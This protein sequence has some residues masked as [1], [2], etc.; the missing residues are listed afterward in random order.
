M[1]AVLRTISACSGARI[2]GCAPPSASDGSFYFLQRLELVL[3][4]VGCAVRYGE[5]FG[6][7]DALPPF[8]H[9]VS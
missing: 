2:V 3:F 4:R 7:V 6:F 9:F 1:V 8:F 5:G